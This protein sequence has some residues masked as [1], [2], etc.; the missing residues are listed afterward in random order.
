M[1]SSLTSWETPLV[2]SQIPF[3]IATQIFALVD[4]NGDERISLPEL[5]TYF[6][7]R[8]EN[9]IGF[10][11]PGTYNE[12]FGDMMLMFDP[13]YKLTDSMI[14]EGLKIR[15]KD[16]LEMWDIDNDGFASYDEISTV[17][18]YFQYFKFRASLIERA[19]SVTDPASG[20]QVPLQIGSEFFKERLGIVDQIMDKIRPNRPDLS[21]L[22]STHK[23]GNKD[24]L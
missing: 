14:E 12:R 22:Q 10:F 15:A 1:N 20:E 11:D 21:S 24:E 4:T 9:V 23:L 17:V 8:D 16:T 19:T 5:E 13:R 18:D 7:S 6:L 3:E 2:T